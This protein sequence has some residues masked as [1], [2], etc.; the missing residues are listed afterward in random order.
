MEAAMEHLRKGTMS[1]TKAAKFHGVP[2]TTLKDRMS[3]KVVHGSKPGRKLYLNSDEEESLA[4]HLVEA[5]SIG[6]G[7]T[8][9]EVK[10]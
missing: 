5:A 4:E 7:K 6:Y 1:M 3:G 9:A 2:S 10:W 8:R